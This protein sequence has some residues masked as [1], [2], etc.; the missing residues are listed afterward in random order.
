MFPNNYRLL[1]IK[2]WQGNF[3]KISNLRYIRGEWKENPKYNFWKQLAERSAGKPNI[4]FMYTFRPCK[5]CN[6]LIC[7]KSKYVH[8][9]E[10]K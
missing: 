3:V 5:K 8:K 4:D 7:D 2:F 6:K 1:K 9:C 10:S